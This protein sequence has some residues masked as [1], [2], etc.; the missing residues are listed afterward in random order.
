MTDARILKKALPYLLSIG[1]VVLII[2]Y[3]SGSFSKKVQPGTL[4]AGQEHV[5][6]RPTDEVHRV[7]ETEQIEVVGTLRAKQRAEVSPKIMAT[8]VELDVTAGDP[9]TKGMVVARL[10]DRDYRAQ[11]EEAKQAVAAA[12]AN[13]GNAK[14]QFERA[15][16]LLAKNAGSKQNYDNSE[17]AY[18]VAQADLRQAEQA[19]SAAATNLSYTVIESPFT[20]IVVNKLVN[21][22]DV[23]TPG[24]P[25]MEIYDPTVLRLEA[26]VPEALSGDIAVG[27][28][29]KVTI[30]ALD[31]TF[32]GTV[33]EIVPQAQAASRSFLVKVLL[34]RDKRMVE[35]MF[36]RLFVP[37]SRRSRY[38]VSEAAIRRIGQL[39]FVDVVGPE[40]VLQRRQVT[41][42]EHAEGGRVE[43]L[44]GLEAGERVVLY[45]PSLT[46]EQR[47]NPTEG[48]AR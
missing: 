29:M 21:V 9:V 5:G 11:L 48:E 14:T 15:R 41:L 12:E 46:S 43:V 3:M 16:N 42:G 35:G 28:E 8:I 20:G 24:K 4:E 6:D 39:R 38:C 36:G 31:A 17:T 34:P 45:G 7:V 44:S 2:M 18:R 37:T 26:A 30:D 40:G 47:P 1:A 32:T 22:G 10:D 33:E 13:V 23:A 25:L 27:D 19:V